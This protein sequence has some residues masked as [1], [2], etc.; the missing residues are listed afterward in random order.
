MGSANGRLIV[1]NATLPNYSQQAPQ[2]V[3]YRPQDKVGR[4]I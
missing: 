3:T 2:E 1:A 4:H